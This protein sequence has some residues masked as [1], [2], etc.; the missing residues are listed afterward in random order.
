MHNIDFLCRRRPI[1]WAPSP[2]VNDG[3]PRT[4]DNADSGDHWRPGYIA[5][6][7]GIALP[8]HQGWF[9]IERVQLLRECE[10]RRGSRP[11]MPLKHANVFGDVMGKSGKTFAITIM[12]KTERQ[13]LLCASN[14]AAMLSRIGNALLADYTKSH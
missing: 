9:V 4:A 14:L 3:D 7:G 13:E 11:T 5:P 10:E 8:E 12:N 6:G 2:R 1:S